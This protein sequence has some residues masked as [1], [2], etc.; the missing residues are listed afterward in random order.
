M[1]SFE[2]A[3]RIVMSSPSTTGAER[4]PLMTAL[5]RILAEDITADLDMPPFDK[6]AV[7]GFACRRADLGSLF[8]SGG[9]GHLTKNSDPGNEPVKP[10]YCDGLKVIETI[11]AGKVPVKTIGTG[12]CSRIMT[13][14]MVP[15]GA[16]C[17]VMVED[18]EETGTGLIR[19]TKTQKSSNICYRAE[20]IRKGSVI[21]T[22]G[23]L[24]NPAAIASLATVGITSPLVSVQPTVAI[25]STG[26][27]LVE[28]D[29]V[30][31]LSQIRNS[32]SWQLMAQL[33]AMGIKSNYQG[34]ARDKPHAL[35]GL[36]ENA[37][38]NN[39]LIL[40]TGGVSMGDYDYVPQVMTEAGFELKFKSV[41]VQPG[42][43]TV[44]G[45]R[46]NRWFFGLPGNPVS[47]FVLFEMLVKPFLYRLMGHQWVPPDLIMPISDDYS[48]R[49]A[50]RKAMVPVKISG[51]SVTPIEYH[52]SAHIHSYTKADAIMIV[53]RGVTFIKKGEPVNVRPV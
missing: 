15:E 46:S 37:C 8:F 33:M 32:N 40:L 3:Y 31:G 44:F 28:P 17:V 34:I 26:D 29:T 12:E 19:V 5:G 11:G 6:A 1:I 41:A 23:T 20:D 21:L 53:E 52:G 24:L 35:S 16:D 43:P 48:R 27:E 36:I 7:D 13:G 10:E 39:Q 25:I 2:E 50:D 51:G 38:H 4:V 45:H 30:P 49:R 22:K 47:S 9:S 18:T 42:K 14:A